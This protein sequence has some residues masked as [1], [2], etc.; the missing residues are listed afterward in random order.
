LRLGKAQ[1]GKK[2]WSPSFAY[3]PLAGWNPISGVIFDMIFFT[4]EITQIN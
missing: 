3:Q 1:L 2:G 4:L